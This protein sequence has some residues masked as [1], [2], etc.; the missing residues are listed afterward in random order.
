MSDTVVV[1][2]G[3]HGGAQVAASLREGGFAEDIIVLS[4]EP[5]APYHRPPLSKAYLKDPSNGLQFLRGEDYYQLN[6][7]DLRLGERAVAIDPAKKQVQLAAGGNITYGHLVLATGARV[8]VPDVPGIDLDGVHYIRTASDSDGMRAELMAGNKIAVVGGGF[9]GLEAAATA[10]QLGKEVVVLEAADRLMGRAV[11]PAISEHFLESHQAAGIDVRLATPL[12]EITT[13]GAKASGVKTTS[14]EI[15]DADLVLVGI[16]VI[17]NIELAETAGLTCKNGIVVDASL[18][19]DDQSIFAIGDCANFPFAK[20]D[21]MIR[22]ES[23]QNATDQARFVAKQILGDQGQFDEVPW[24]WSDQADLKLQMAGLGIGADRYVTRG[25]PAENKFSV[26]H[27]ANEQIIALDSVNAPAD[28]MVFRK[29]LGSGTLPT[30]EQ[31]A[32]PN[33]DLRAFFKAAR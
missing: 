18:R 21:A 27:I 16:G 11:A 23:V 13:D 29:L 25:I 30:P 2:G 14:G 1:I 33:F 17:P 28:H 4:D 3:S 15:I 31:I 12:A 22:L 19:T 32:D 5:Y 10:R 9:I 6:D 26:A 20:T 8:R 24:F 7:I